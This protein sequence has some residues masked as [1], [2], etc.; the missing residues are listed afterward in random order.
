MRDLK[1][2]KIICTHSWRGHDLP[3]PDYALWVLLYH[4]LRQI[5][6]QQ[7]FVRGTLPG[8]SVSRQFDKGPGFCAFGVE[9]AFELGDGVADECDED[10]WRGGRVR[11][12]EAGMG[13]PQ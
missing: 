7:P 11:V 1:C 3:R 5:L 13:G 4:A 6:P 8:L 10:Y 9:V 2:F 12:K